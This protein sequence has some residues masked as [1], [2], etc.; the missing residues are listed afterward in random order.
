MGNFQS[1]ELGEELTV[2]CFQCKDCDLMCFVQLVNA[3][4]LSQ[5]LGVVATLF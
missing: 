1:V 3:A 5:C 2:S 4:L